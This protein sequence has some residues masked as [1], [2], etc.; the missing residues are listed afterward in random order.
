MR[1]ISRL[2]I[3]ALWLISHILEPPSYYFDAV[4]DDSVALLWA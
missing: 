2:A 3:K 4:A 1:I